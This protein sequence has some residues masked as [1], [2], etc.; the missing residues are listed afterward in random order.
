[1][2]EAVVVVGAG[3]AGLACARELSALGI[4]A[5]V[6]DKGRGVGGRC[7]TRRVHGRSVD[8]GVA[9][10]HGSDRSFL[11]TLEAV[12]SDG[13]L[14]GWPRRVNGSGPPCQ[15]D[16]F[17]PG[18]SR[19]AFAEGLS[20][21]PKHLARGLDV[22]LETR[23]AAIAAGDGAFRVELEGGEALSAAT[24]VLTQPVEQASA[25]LAAVTAPEALAARE[26]L[27][28]AGT[29]PCLTVLAGY[30][31]DAPAPEWD[32]SYP[33]G[34]SFLQL[35]SHDSTKRTAPGGPVLVYQ[36]LPRWSRQ[37]FDSPEDAWGTEVLAEAALRVGAWAGRPAWWQAHRWRY[38]RADGAA[39]LRGPLLAESPGSGRLGLAGELFSPEGGVQ[40]A[41]RSGRILA[42]RI[43]GEERT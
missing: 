36:C 1:M 40:G 23:V 2:D 6:L 38:A 4:P 30:P 18:E 11:E 29:V 27:A 42:R 3:V 19:L 17:A 34:A 41:W 8:H 26:L 22:R 10:L 14:P 35:I 39:A 16:A 5:V 9:F 31:D 24:V 13:R 12:A 25:L 28:M 33:G 32:V 21:F 43:A 20:A 37:R 15:P 7:A